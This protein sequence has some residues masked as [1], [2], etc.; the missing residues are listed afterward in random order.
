MGTAPFAPSARAG[1][2]V[3]FK[4][5]APDQA[6]VYSNLKSGDAGTV[7]LVD[8]R[9]AVHVKWDNGSTLGLMAGDRFRLISTNAD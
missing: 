1:D 8:D 6:D 4:E 7:I 3:E 9:G 5:F 2:R